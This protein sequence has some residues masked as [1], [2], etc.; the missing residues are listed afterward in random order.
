MYS[1]KKIILAVGF[2]AS[3]IVS[4][5]TLA[6]YSPN[7]ALDDG[8]DLYDDNRY[9]NASEKLETLVKSRDFRQ[10]DA[11]EKSLA[12]TYLIKGKI[13]QGNPRGAM[14]H[15]GNLIKLSKRQFG[16]ASIEHADAHYW[17]AVAQYRM[18]NGR[19]AGRSVDS[20]AQIF[21]R[22]GDDYRDNV[23][24]AWRLASRARSGEWDEDDL[25]KDLS[26]FY[27]SCEAINKGDNLPSA[28]RTMS[29]FTWIGRDLKPK[30]STK[31]WFERTY[32]KHAREN[33]KDRANRFIFVPDEDHLD[34]WCVIYPGQKKLV[35]RAVTSP[36]ES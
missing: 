8:L 17:K 12:L 18:G 35:D 29:E 25:P 19:D 31:R 13:Q 23:A 34:H 15:A 3:L 21:E 27:T 33:A 5:S 7:D 22:M 26:D 36:P 20:M 30:G 11:M 10:L 4:A 16:N 28:T 32:I 6:Y 9:R 1:R 2:L 14:L 24:N